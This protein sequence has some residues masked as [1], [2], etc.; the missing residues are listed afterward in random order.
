MKALKAY[1]LLLS[2]L[3]LVS[4]QGDSQK[5]DFRNYN[6]L[7]STE[8]NIDYEASQED[9]PTIEIDLLEVLAT[10]KKSEKKAS[11]IN[12][13]IL[14]RYTD[15][16]TFEEDTNLDLEKAVTNFIN[17]YQR[18][19]AEFPDM[20]GIYELNLN[21]RPTY[22]SNRFLSVKVQ[23]YTYTGGAHG[24]NSIQFM[25]FNLKTG[26]EYI[27]QTQLKDESAFLDYTESEFRRQRDI[28]SD[29]NLNEFGYWFEDEK[30]QLPRE[31]GFD[32]D[33]LILIYNPYEI[34]SY[35]DGHIIIEIPIEEVKPYFD[36]KLD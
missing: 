13:S 16:I 25:N 14:D 19:K 17:A 4:C 21:A 30:F 2:I 7:D 32:G 8:F 10:D 22:I 27:L 1:F 12:Q 23:S 18:D 28:E 3:F 11:K 20:A 36:I 29:L 5:F 15:N 26:D 33:K 34:A 35:A 6:I 24:Y 9:F 31:M